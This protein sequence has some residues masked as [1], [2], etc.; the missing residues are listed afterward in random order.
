M[1]PSLAA[2]VLLLATGHKARFTTK[3]AVEPV[4]AGALLCGEVLGGARLSRLPPGRHRRRE[5]RA[6]LAARAR[7][8]RHEVAGPL[9]S[10][11]V[12]VPL[13][14]RVLGFVVR[15]GFA[16]L[17]GSAQAVAETRLRTVLLTPTA[18]PGLGALAV[19]CA[20]SGIAATVVPPPRDRRSRRALAAHLNGLRAVVGPDLAEVL[21]A[22]RDAYRRQHRSDGSFVP[23][24][25]RD[26]YGDSGGDGGDGGG[27]DGGG[28]D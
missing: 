24:S 22:T 28:G 3:G 14:H 17:D 5:I 20:V 12:L 9:V 18:D 10:A 4:L 11:G 16:V 27:G 1:Q 25:G 23:D 2:D 19:L 15:R 8:A 13:E 21:T 6:V 7:V 26:P